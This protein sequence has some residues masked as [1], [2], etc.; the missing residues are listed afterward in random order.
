MQDEDMGFK[1]KCILNSKM[2]Y[3]KKVPKLKMSLLHVA[4]MDVFSPVAVVE[5]EGLSGWAEPRLSE[6]HW[7][8]A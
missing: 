7:S 2:F 6:T 8:V 5:V 3:K 4:I 1:M